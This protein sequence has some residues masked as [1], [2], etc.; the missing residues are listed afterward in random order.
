MNFISV[1]SQN[2]YRSVPASQRSISLGL[3]GLLVSLF[4]TL[5]SPTIWGVIIDSACLVWNHPCFNEKV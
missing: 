4:G 1:L 2:I 3:Q 5:P